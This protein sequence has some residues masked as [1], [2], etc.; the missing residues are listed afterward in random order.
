[1]QLS[2]RPYVTTG[3]AIV[4][5]S[6]LVAAPM[7]VTPP[8]IQIAN[9]AVQVQR[10]VEL[11]ANEI[12]NAVNQLVFAATKASVSIAQLTTPLVAQILGVPEA[13][14][15]AFLTIGT[16]GLLGPLFSGTGAVGT[17]LQDVVDSN[18]LEDL[19]VN[20]IGAP[21]TIIDGVVNGGYGPNLAS[22]AI[23]AL[24]ALGE[25]PN[26]PPNFWPTVFSGGLINGADAVPPI[27]LPGTIPTLQGLIEQLFGLFSPA[28]AM[29]A[30]SAS[31]LAAPA[32][33]STVEDG[34]NSLLFTLTKATLSIVELAAPLVAPILG[35]TNEQAKGFLALGAV[36]LLGPLISG[37]GAAGAAIQ[38]ILNSDGAEELINNLIGAPAT[39]IDG[40]V[41]G[42]Y[43]PNLAPLIGEFI[44][45]PLPVLNIFAGGLINEAV[46]SPIF[47]P[48]S[49][50]PIGVGGTFQGTI[51]TLQGLVEQL[52][53]L[54][55][56]AASASTFAAPTGGQTLKINNN[57]TLPEIKGGTDLD[58]QAPEKAPELTPKPHK[59]LVNIDVLGNGSP[60][61]GGNLFH[62]DQKTD[63]GATK[64]TDVKPVNS[65][66]LGDGK[67]GGVSVHDVIK[68]ITGHGNDTKPAGAT[69]EATN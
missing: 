33:D 41:N 56:S 61:G 9:P 47:N 45:S 43:G 3:V 40:L 54:L 69:A 64:E 11:T 1:M 42:G 59:H 57:T 68:R 49:P 67:I 24:I 34:I 52:F 26:V 10:A 29:S 15:A 19:L 13:Q 36:G 35:V 58:G 65:H 30:Q 12:E 55:P 60:L 23:P 18:G 25:F 31:L 39:I 53:G 2:L 14:A 17:A 6:V 46:L 21:G 22:L 38:D 20:L 62:K 27:I 7:T 32:P 51:P 28:A 50:I 63:S 8:D 44:P 5:A 48:P 16:I 66:R 37:P 4:G